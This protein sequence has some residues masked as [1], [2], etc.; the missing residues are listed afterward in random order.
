MTHA[1]QELFLLKALHAAEHAHKEQ[2]FFNPVIAAAQAALESNW[3]RSQL[4]QQANNLK[5]VKAGSSWRGDTIE[6][7]TREWREAD[8]TWYTTTARWRKYPNWAA[9]FL[10]YGDLIER[11]YPHA[12]AVADDATGFLD[13]LTARAYPKY[14]TDPAYTAKVWSIITGSNVL[15]NALV[16]GSK[17]DLLIVLGVGGEELFRVGVPTGGRII[18]NA[19]SGKT[20]VRIAESLE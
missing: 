6:L 16:D 17:A 13:Q 15:S 2:P 10:D 3:G 7:P 11:V 20:Y 9:A 12:A 4:A 5:G 14:A 8:D 18:L 1:E 19:G